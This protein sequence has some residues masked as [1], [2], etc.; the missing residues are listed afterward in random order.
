MNKTFKP[1][2]MRLVIDLNFLT[3]IIVKSLVS[4]RISSSFL[5]VFF[6]RLGESLPERVRQTPRLYK[7]QRGGDA[8]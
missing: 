2:L 7:Y 4:F 1:S 6:V 5:L 8:G 3:F